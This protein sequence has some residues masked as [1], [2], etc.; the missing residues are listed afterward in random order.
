[1]RL[2]MHSL[3]FRSGRKGHLTCGLFDAHKEALSNDKEKIGALYGSQPHLMNSLVANNKVH[4]EMFRF[5]EIMTSPC[6][7]QGQ[8]NKTLLSSVT[9]VPSGLMGCALAA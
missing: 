1:M 6:Y 2:S 4:E 8:A 9:H 7:L 5:S 3:A